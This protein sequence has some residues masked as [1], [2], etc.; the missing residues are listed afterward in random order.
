MKPIVK[1]WLEVDVLRLQALVQAGASVTRCS[2]AL[3]RPSNAVR[4]QAR[5]MGMPFP[6]IRVLKRAQK[7]KIAAAEL[8]LAPGSLRY[9]GSRT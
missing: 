7:I 8:T 5:R 1:G 6:G 9:D 3:N 2:A 4:N